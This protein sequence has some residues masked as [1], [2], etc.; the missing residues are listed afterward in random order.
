MSM[1]TYNE[2]DPKNSSFFRWDEINHVLP[3]KKCH[4]WVTILNKNEQT[5]KSTKINMSKNVIV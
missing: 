2:Y 5:G 4:D 3:G 1:K